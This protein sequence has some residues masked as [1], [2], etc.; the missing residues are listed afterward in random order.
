MVAEVV[1]PVS[2]SSS[3]QSVRTAE[4]IEELAASDP[5]SK[6]VYDSYKQYRDGVKAYHAISEHAYLNAR[7]M[8]EEEVSEK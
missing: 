8:A 2:A 6:K 5:M 3:A 1:S 4:L 7:A